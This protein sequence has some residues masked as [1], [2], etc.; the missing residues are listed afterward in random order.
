MVLSKDDVVAARSGVITA[1]IDGKVVELAEV[2]S[3]TASIEITKADFKALGTK[4]V[5]KKPTGWTGTGS[6]TIYFSTSQWNKI[7]LN[8]TKYGKV[9]NFN[10]IMTIEDTATS[11]GKQTVTLSRCTLDGGDIAKLDTDAD[12]LDA[13]YNFTFED[14]DMPEE[15]SQYTSIK[16]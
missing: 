6:M 7:I 1:T 2:K 14:W 9:T 5:Q 4:A 10:I 12:F 3:L 15:F 13:S 8:Y 16:L 11:I